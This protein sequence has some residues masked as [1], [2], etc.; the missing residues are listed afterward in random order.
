MAEVRRIVVTG[1]Y[2]FIGSALVR[3]LAAQDGVSV[4][5]IDKK[6]YAA[7]PDAIAGLTRCSTLE[8]DICDAAAMRDAIADF[9]PDAIFHLAAETHVDRSIEAPASFVHTNVGGTL[10]ILEA[11]LVYWQK[12]DYARS[13][14]FR[15][16]HVSTDEVYGDLALDG[17]DVFREDDAYRPNSPYAASKAGADHLVRAW[18]KTYGL[19]TIISNCSNNY[20]PWQLPEKLIPKTLLSALA[21]QSIPVYGAGLNVRDWIYVEDHV[22]ALLRVADRGAPGC[23]YIAGGNGAISNIELVR[24]IAGILDTAVPESASVPH[25]QL[26]EFVADRPGHDLRYEVDPGRLRD[27]LG[28]R[29]AHGLHAGL[30]K[31]VQWYIANRDRYDATAND[32]IA[33]RLGRGYGA[34]ASAQGVQ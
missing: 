23:Q 24:T 14:A 26:I 31:T 6:T 16:V 5:S 4:L 15:F 17:S 9:A 33:T 10:S 8:A 22:D 29:A 32:L 34:H 21:G 7:Q 19:P 27:E 3:R 13:S 2:G 25:G 20:G 18:Q 11:A 30:A 28:W 12:L 1:G